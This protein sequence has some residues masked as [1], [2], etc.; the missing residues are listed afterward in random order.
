MKKVEASL[1][2]GMGVCS[3]PTKV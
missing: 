2:A 1:R 3:I